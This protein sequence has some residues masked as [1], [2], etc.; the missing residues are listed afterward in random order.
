MP[1]ASANKILLLGIDGLDPRLT[2]KYLDE[3]KMPNTRALLERGAARQDLKM[4][5]FRQMWRK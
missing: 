5:L 1:T 4:C 2:R 3:G